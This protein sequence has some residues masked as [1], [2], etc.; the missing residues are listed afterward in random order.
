MPRIREGHDTDE[1]LQ[2]DTADSVSPVVNYQPADA[3]DQCSSAIAIGAGINDGQGLQLQAQV[4]ALATMESNLLTYRAGST[5]AMLA[6]SPCAA[7]RV[8]ARAAGAAAGEPHGRPARHDG[9]LTRSRCPGCSASF[10]GGRVT[11]SGSA[12]PTSA[13]RRRRAGNLAGHTTWGP[14]GRTASTLQSTQAEN[15]LLARNPG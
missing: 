15:A 11:V 8:A 14:T 5:R 4:F 10:I 13:W 9:W 3:T 2:A 1:V 6:I 7:C 12:C